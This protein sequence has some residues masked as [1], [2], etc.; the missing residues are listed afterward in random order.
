MGREEFDKRVFAVLS[1]IFGSVAIILL[2]H[3]MLTWW[4]N[5][6][7]TLMQLIKHHT[8]ACIAFFVC[9]KFG[10]SSLNL[11]KK[12]KEDLSLYSFGRK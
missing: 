8:F 6:E 12:A 2:A 9:D 11:Y 10:G 5:D 7:W 4:H 3:L 1:G